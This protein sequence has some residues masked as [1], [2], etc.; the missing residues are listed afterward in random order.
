MRWFLFRLDITTKRFLF[1]GAT[2]RFFDR[3]D[4]RRRLG[5]RFFH[6]PPD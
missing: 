1:Y 4:F 5:P 6:Y 2:G 3:W